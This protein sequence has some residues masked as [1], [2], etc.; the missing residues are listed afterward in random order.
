MTNIGCILESYE[1]GI[2]KVNDERPD[3][4]RKRVW[5][6]WVSTCET[7]RDVR[8]IKIKVKG[9]DDVESSRLC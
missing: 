7:E 4:L 6:V 1:N 9:Y 2:I 5:T 3:K 8:L